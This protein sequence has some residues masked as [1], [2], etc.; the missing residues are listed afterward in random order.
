[1]GAFECSTH[2]DTRP[3]PSSHFSARAAAAGGHVEKKHQ[4]ASNLLDRLSVLDAS[5]ALPAVSADVAA[6]IDTEVQ[7]VQQWRQSTSHY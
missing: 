2:T 3:V 7:E 6:H 4:S 1:M 5:K